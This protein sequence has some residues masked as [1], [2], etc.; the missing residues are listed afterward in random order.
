M[1]ARPELADEL[2]ARGWPLQVNATSLVGYH[3][4]EIEQLGWRL[5]EDG[6]VSLVASDGHRPSR[7]ARLDEAFARAVERVGEEAALPLFDGSALGLAQSSIQ[8]QS[9]SVADGRMGTAQTS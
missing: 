9:V 7:P 1:L 4:P 3:G 5:V 8:T 6:V 2:A